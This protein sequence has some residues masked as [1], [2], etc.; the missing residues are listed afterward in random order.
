MTVV[1]MNV[2]AYLYLLGEHTAAAEA[3]LE[4]DWAASILD[5][6]SCATYGGL[7]QAKDTDSRPV[8]AIGKMRHLKW[9]KQ[10][11]AFDAYHL[12]EELAYA[13]SPQDAPTQICEVR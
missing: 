9:V 6:A 1:D 5:A 7:H 10:R 8:Q 4:C 13:A 3:L 2:I 12:N 11:A